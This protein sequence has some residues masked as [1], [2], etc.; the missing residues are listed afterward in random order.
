MK[1]IILILS[2]VILTASC[3]SSTSKINIKE[4]KSNIIGE[5]VYTS[6]ISVWKFDAPSEIKE[7]KIINQKITGELNELTAEYI[8]E[9]F[10]SINLYYL[11]A[12]HVF[13]N[14]GDKW[15]LV[16]SYSMEIRNVSELGSKQTL[17]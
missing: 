7:V 13:R 11:K 16:N 1:K 15:N 10:R 3:N 6:G 5:N 2:L 14:D 17:D 8:L 12:G 4:L 9:D